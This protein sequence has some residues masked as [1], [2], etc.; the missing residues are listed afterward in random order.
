[1]QKVKCNKEKCGKEVEGLEV[2]AGASVLCPHCYNWIDIATENIKK[3][4]DLHKSQ[5]LENWEREQLKNERRKSGN[6]QK[7]GRGSVNALL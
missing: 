3:R 1:M 4:R 6:K 5:D 7:N 2:P